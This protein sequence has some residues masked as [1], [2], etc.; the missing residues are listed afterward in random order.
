MNPL[1]VTVTSRIPDRAREPYYRYDKW[2]ESMT[3]QGVVPKILGMGEPWH[4]LIS[5][6]KIMRDWLRTDPVGGDVIIWSDSYDV[7]F[8]YHPQEVIDY[9]KTN[10]RD[11]SVV[12]NAEKGLFPRNDLALSFDDPGT[13]WRY[14]NSGLIIGPANS[15]L[16]ILE[17]M[18]LD[19]TPGDYIESDTGRNINPNDQGWH[20]FAY[21]AQ[22]IA[23]ALDSGCQMFQT[24]SACGFD[25]FDLSGPKVMNRVTE[26]C[27]MVHH[28]N[29]DSKDRLLDRFLEKWGL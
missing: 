14:L 10:W 9:Y 22:P 1:V 21:S 3:R 28:F 6:P 11:K 4:G 2:L 23:M 7:V 15:I 18:P 8:P 20:Q 16:R 29:G 25:E 26:T 5:K 13:P 27:P 17:W 19:D 24:Y 12:Y